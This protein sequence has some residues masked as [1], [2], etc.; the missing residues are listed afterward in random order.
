MQRQL[1]VNMVNCSSHP[2]N[3]FQEIYFT[4]VLLFKNTHG[5]TKYGRLTLQVVL[6]IKV[7]KIEG[8]LQQALQQAQQHNST[9]L[10]HLQIALLSGI[11][12]QKYN[13]LP[14][15]TV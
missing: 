14:F 11:T 4:V 5:T 12:K 2:A 15:T 8:Q 13:K 9:M 6:N 7:C 3:A 10:I 1:S